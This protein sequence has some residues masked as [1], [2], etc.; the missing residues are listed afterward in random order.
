[1]MVIGDQ[2]LQGG[3]RIVG[4][5]PAGNL[6]VLLES[7]DRRRLGS[8]DPFHLQVVRQTNPDAQAPGL[9]RGDA[10]IAGLFQL[11]RKS[12]VSATFYPAKS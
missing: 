7:L 12:G 5:D 8:L 2:L 9:E 1:M 11:L 3:G 10:Q 6:Q 4:P